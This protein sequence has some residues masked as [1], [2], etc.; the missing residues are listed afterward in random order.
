[1]ISQVNISALGLNIIGDAGNEPTICID[2]L[3]PDRVAIGWRQFDTISSNFRQAGNACSLDGGRTWHNNPVVEPG[4]FRSDPIMTAGSDGV[5]YFN[6]LT[7]AP[8][9]RC[10]VSRSLDGGQTWSAPVFAFGGDKTWMTID[11]SGGVGEGLLHQAWSTASNPT[12]G[13][14]YCR[15]ING[16]ATWSTPSVLAG[17]AIWGTLTVGLSGEL[18]VVGQSGGQ[19]RVTRSV[20]AGNPAAPAVVFDPHVVVSLSGP[21]RGIGG[22]PNPGGLSGQIW[23]D[24][25]RSN[26]PHRGRLFVCAVV[27]PAGVDQADVSLAW[28]DDGGASWSAPVRVN[29][30]ALGANNWQWFAAM[31]VAPNGRVDVTWNDTHESGNPV[32]SRL[33]YASSDDGG[34]TWTPG[35]AV[36][37]EFDSTIGY[38]N[39]NKMGDYTHQVS[40]LT[41]CSLAWA[42]TF[43][44]GQD[45]YLAR[46]GA[47]DCNQN[48]VDDALDIGVGTAADCNGDGVPDSCQIKAGYVP[49]GNHNGVPDPCE[50]PCAADMTHA[51]VAGRPGYGVPNAVLNNDDFFYF[52]AQFAL[53]NLAR[54]D[55]TTTAVPGSL[56]YGTPNGVLNNDDFFYYLSLF[57]AGC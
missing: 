49:D 30:D 32:L 43:T 16:G 14:Q 55:L 53:G 48:G 9:F 35:L 36:S 39:Q 20:S 1:M 23:I 13:N 25:D 5:F 8:E 51:A 22:A 15:S 24:M 29:D 50:N 56:G 3:A 7:Q 52:I 54:A 44:G 41:G 34:V 40:D 45:V 28:S 11:R 21:A 27:D 46:I 42:G 47:W 26:G 6:T 18:Y 12:P 4:V 33:Y 17:S 37:P 31:S 38:P 19:V 2:P 57:A 10:G